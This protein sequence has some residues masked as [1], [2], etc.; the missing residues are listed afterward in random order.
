MVAALSGRPSLITL[1][2]N[3]RAIAKTMKPRPFS[4]YWLNAWIE[5]FCIPR[6]SGVICISSH[7]QRSVQELNPQTWVI[8]N[9][10]GSSWFKVVPEPSPT[11]AI[12][13]I[14]SISDIKNQ[15]LLVEAGDAVHELY[16][17]AVFHFHG[18]CDPQSAYGKSFLA[19][20]ATRPWCK[21]HGFSSIPELQAALSRATLLVHPS[22][23]ENCPMVI[24]EAMSAGIPVA[25]SRA[26]GI[27]DLID[28]G[29]NGFL[30]DLHQPGALLETISQLLSSPEVP[31]RI[32]AQTRAT[33]LALFSPQAIAEAHVRAYAN[34]ASRQ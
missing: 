32:A 11:P 29:K 22:R 14:G 3:F 33:A 30:F 6:V 21:H 23:E 5:A 20:I 19:A 28:S 18:Q 1:H 9:P 24:L 16:P 7:T 34:V 15:L 2:G 31:A 4:Y 13:C 26:G 27:P 17:D 12:L 25:A 8:P 10:V